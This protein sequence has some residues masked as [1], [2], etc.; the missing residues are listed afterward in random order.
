MKAVA[1]AI[2]A[3]LTLGSAA[4]QEPSKLQRALADVKAYEQTHF[5]IAIRM[6]TIVGRSVGRLTGC[7]GPA[8]AEAA[9]RTTAADI[10]EGYRE[11]LAKTTKVFNDFA[12]DPRRLG[13]EIKMMALLEAEASI[14]P[15]ECGGDAGDR[16]HKELNRLLGEWVLNSAY[17]MLTIAAVEE[18][19]KKEAD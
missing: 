4:A 9:A 8:A 2:A 12:P 6:A 10:V 11:S 1:I 14:P 3:A 16:A 13:L 15:A 7:H 17:A 19:R 5:D 18:L